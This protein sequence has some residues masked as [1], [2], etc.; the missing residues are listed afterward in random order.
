MGRLPE[1]LQDKRDSVRYDSMKSKT[2]IALLLL[3]LMAVGLTL[4]WPAT[5]TPR[6]PDSIILISIDTIRA[7]HMS[8]Y[9]YPRKTTPAIDAFAEEAFLFES[10]FANIP[11]TM[12]SHA[13]MLTGMIPPAHGVLD[14][15]QMALAAS[16]TTLPEI[17][18]GQGYQTYGIVSAG[19][20]DKR[21][22]LDQGF[23]DYDDTFLGEAGRA[24]QIPQR[25]GD[26]TVAQ[27]LAWLEKHRSDRKFMFIHFYDPHFEYDPPAPFDSQFDHPYDGEIAFTD[28][29]IGQILDRLK[30]L[31]LYENA[32]IIVTGDHAE[33]LGEHGEAEHGLFIYRNVLHVPL[34]IK[35]AGLSTSRH[36]SDNTGVTDIAPT[37]LSQCGLKATSTVQG[38]D[39][40]DYFVKK[41]HAIPDRFLFN[42]CLTAT[43]YEG[44][45]LMGVIHNQWHYIQTTRPE[46]YDHVAD[47]QELN[48]LVIRETKRARLLQEH[49]SEI[50]DAAEIGA[51]TADASVTDSSSWALRSLGYVGGAIDPSMKFDRSRQDPK[52]LVQIHNMLHE[53]RVLTHEKKYDEALA[54]GHR[55]LEARSDVRPAYQQLADLYRLT[56]SY[57]N[58]ID[59]LQKQLELMP[60]NP[61]TMKDLSRTYAQ[62]TRYPL[63]IAT[64]KEVLQ[65]N[66][67]DLEVLEILTNLY[68][69]SKSFDLAI[70]TLKKRL[71]LRPDDVSVFKVM[72]HTYTWAGKYDEAIDIVNNQILK[73]SPDDGDAY[74]TLAS[75]YVKL[76]EYDK[77]IAASQKRVSL[78]PDNAAA[79]R[80]LAQIYIEAE[81]FTKAIETINQFLE[82]NPDDAVAYRKLADAY[83][84]QE[85]YQ[86]AIK[87]MQ[88]LLTLVPD[89]VETLLL[90]ST[91]CRTMKDFK[92]ALHYAEKIADLQPNDAEAWYRI[93]LCQNALGDKA[94]AVENC[95]KALELDSEHFEARLSAAETY[96]KV[97]KFQEAIKHFTIVF[98]KKADL[99][100]QLNNIAWVQAT[101]QDPE[102]YDPATALTYAERAADIAAQADSPAHRYYPQF[103]D[104]LAI[105]QAANDRFAE[106]I[107]TAEKAL[108]LCRQRKQDDQA[109]KI[110]ARLDLY[111][112]GKSYRE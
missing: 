74:Q 106:A 7:D 83:I 63:A 40:S 4:F 5:V 35:P 68:N 9:G 102:V 98:E 1:A 87:V 8:C 25:L 31:G 57:D 53:V 33:M 30:E 111:K 71:A 27:S 100:F 42:V 91:T 77:A 10:C 17:L 86:K 39:L 18:Q 19:V 73:A 89:D 49:L 46:L 36:V 26:E 54:L 20:L 70:A 79:L 12:P 23:D 92:Q 51:K 65:A 84:K 11:L 47:P 99:P 58:A 81:N 101:H 24:R 88:K 59:M 61:D 110:A 34:L 38:V 90:L 37:I 44:N 14:N 94:S 62:A 43:K 93:G 13:S 16:I 66:P 29:C 103:L 41:N 52:D 97:G 96:R 67:K 76:E 105:A 6:T 32:L 3:V 85:L 112:Q 22:G 48:N 21:Y 64:L 82:S 72:A 75:V 78:Q 109:K 95:E 15:E 28:H 55:V 107:T 56:G 104:T 60:G 45:S 2:L 50:L 80:A 69:A 108:A